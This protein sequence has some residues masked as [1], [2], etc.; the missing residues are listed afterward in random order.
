MSDGSSWRFCPRCGETKHPDEFYAD[1]PQKGRKRLKRRMKCRQS[2]RAQMR[3]RYEH[4]QGE[5]DAYKLGHGCTDCG[6]AEHPRA[7]EF[8]HLPG[9]GKEATIANLVAG[10]RPMEEV[11]AEIAKCEVVCAN[12]HRMRT[13]ARE[14]GNTDWD[15]RL[16]SR[17]PEEIAHLLGGRDRDN[18]PFEQLSL[19]V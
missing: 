15:L 7:L 1:R 13:Y 3:A 11:F 8:D 6:W 18:P 19:E 10:S 5:V 2:T 16:S 12:C 9:S 14:H 17:S 4:R